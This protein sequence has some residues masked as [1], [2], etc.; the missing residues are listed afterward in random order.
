MKHFIEI[1]SSPIDENCVQIELCRCYINALL[2]EVDIFKKQLE[3]LFP[4]T[5]PNNSFAVKTFQYNFDFYSVVVCYY[6]D[7]DK[8][9]VD[10]A[11]NIEANT[12]EKW[13]KEA[14]EE[15]Q[16]SDVLK[17]YWKKIL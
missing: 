10:F 17:D 7:S 4:I 8:E 14:L 12:P 15:I 2:I 9:S 13:D 1:G 11:F 3:R 16:N 5:N 6:D